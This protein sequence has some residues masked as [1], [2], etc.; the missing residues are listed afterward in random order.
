MPNLK[1]RFTLETNLAFQTF[2]AN[3]VVFATRAICETLK[4]RVN[5]LNLNFTRHHTIT[6]TRIYINNLLKFLSPLSALYHR[7]GT[8]TELSLLLEPLMFLSPHLRSK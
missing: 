5:K 6:Y 3:Y 4:T 8:V 2:V 1:L 7:I